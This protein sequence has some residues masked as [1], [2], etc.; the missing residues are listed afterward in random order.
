MNKIYTICVN[1]HSLACIF[2]HM[3]A[4]IFVLYSN[5][6]VS[7]NKIGL[8]KKNR[9]TENLQSGEKERAF[10]LDDRSECDTVQLHLGSVGTREK[11]YRT[12][13]AH[14]HTG[15][16]GFGKVNQRFNHSVADSDMGH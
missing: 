11:D 5:L 13:R 1:L 12:C 8:R 9:S 7:L 2:T 14:Y 6:Q 10:F 16:L 4:F 3:F 15:D